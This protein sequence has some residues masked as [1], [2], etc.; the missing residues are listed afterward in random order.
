MPGDP[1]PGRAGAAPAAVLA[2]V[3]CAALGA[4]GRSE[5]SAL[6][7]RLELP[8]AFH[9]VRDRQDGPNRQLYFRSARDHLAI[10]RYP[11]QD[12]GAAARLMEGHRLSIESLFRPHYLPYPGKVSSRRMCPP[13]FQ[14]VKREER[15]RAQWRD[16]YRL[17]SGARLGFGGCSEE[18]NP[19]R[20]AVV[21][22]YCLRSRLLLRLDFH[23][24][25]QA[26]S[27]DV[28]DFIAA[29]RCP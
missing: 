22:L 17:Y 23:T 26:P 15:T 2:C 20:A 16:S 7:L 19:Y 13:R 18:V 14:P 5:I 29:V 24:P 1:H 10:R 25:R 8:G 11:G 4:C 12:L 3:A 21:L 27:V 28:E 9:L 6:G